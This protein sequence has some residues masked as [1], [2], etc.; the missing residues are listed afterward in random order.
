MKVSLTKIA[1]DFKEIAGKDTNE[2]LRTSSCD[3]T[4]KR[5]AAALNRELS[6]LRKLQIKYVDGDKKLKD[7]ITNVSHDL[8]TP[9]TVIY[10]YAEKL[11]TQITDT[12]QLKQIEMIYSRTKE[13]ISLTE[14]L[15]R[16]AVFTDTDYT[17]NLE[18]LNVNEILESSM[19]D[20]YTA[21]TAR[22]IE[23]VID[24]CD[25]P[26]TGLTDRQSLSRIFSNVISN[27]IK[28]AETDFSVKM[29]ADGVIVFSNSA[30][31]LNYINVERLLDRY[32]TVKNNNVSTGLGL[33]IARLLAEKSNCTVTAAYSDG[34]LNIAVT[35]KNSLE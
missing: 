10:G 30:P 19:L 27:A 18:K 15:F 8:R 5:T 21:F 26:V 22:G 23:P 32:Y 14:E 4:I 7:A 35:I 16:Y 24:I 2:L 1:C 29:T 31:K 12:E 34:R 25:E 6:A 9:L 3:K 33:S 11:K 17:P 20:F 13:L 28:Y